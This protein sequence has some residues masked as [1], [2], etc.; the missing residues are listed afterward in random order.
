MAMD[1]D[2][3]EDVTQRPIAVND[4]DLEVDFEELEEE[5]QL[6]SFDSSSRVADFQVRM[7][8]RKWIQNYKMPLQNSLMIFK[9][10]HRI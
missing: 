4:Y 10:C 6:V 3:E 8:L 7:V 5:E 1:I 9:R 2:H